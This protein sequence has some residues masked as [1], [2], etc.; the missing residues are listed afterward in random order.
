MI[1]EK[2]IRKEDARPPLKQSA[3]VAPKMAHV[4]D[5]LLWSLESGLLDT[6]PERFVGASAY[7]C[8]MCLMALLVSAM[9][10]R[11]GA[12]V[13][14]KIIIY[15]V[16]LA[17]MK[18]TV[19]YVYEY[20]FVFVKFLTAT[21]MLASSIAGFAAQG[22][23]MAR[24]TD[25]SRE[26]FVPSY[27]LFL[28]IIPCALAFAASLA[29]NNMALVL[30]STSFTEIFGATSPLVTVAF[31]VAMGM[32]FNPTLLG[33]IIVVIVGCMLSAVG[34]MKF[35]M[36]G[37]LLCFLANVMR[38]VRNAIQQKFLTG[39][40]GKAMMEPAPLMAWTCAA[41]FAVMIVWSLATEGLE[42]WQKLVESSSLGRSRTGLWGA[43]FVSCVNASILNAA[44]LFVTKDLGAVG[45]QIV[46]QLKS[47]ATVVGGMALFGD[48]FSPLE[49]FGF[50]F[51]LVGTGWFSHMQM[52]HKQQEKK[53]NSQS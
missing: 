28:G 7:P 12:L 41:S 23:L 15:L 45:A 39:A 44:V 19:K 37:A 5:H 8:A 14:T 46:S 33:P 30:C 16:A 17:S 3:H 9:Y 31:V 43:L 21:H 52:Q 18:L 25:G 36:V 32:P 49:Y 40:E 27:D 50:A 35:S 11:S 10:Y 24:R 20:D 42:P 4:H 47:I 2:V 38:G 48:S 22:I 6:T 53:Q 51:V 34:E 1:P 13:V 26:R 29:S